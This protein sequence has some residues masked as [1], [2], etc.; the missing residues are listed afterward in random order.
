[1]VQLEV[2]NKVFK[3]LS[4]DKEVT[5]LY[6]GVPNPF[7]TS[8]TTQKLS[9]S[10]GR[11]RRKGEGWGLFVAVKYRNIYLLIRVDLTD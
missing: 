5:H 8:N 1:M 10:L 2:L 9:R 6:T 7:P 4:I 11:E 3:L